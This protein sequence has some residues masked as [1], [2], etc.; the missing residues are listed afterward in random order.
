M[1]SPR[2][3]FWGVRGSFPAALPGCRQ[4][5]GNTAC[6]E[7]EWQGYHLIVDSGTG[8]RKLGERLIANPPGTPLHLLLSHPHWD[9]IQGFPFFAPAYSEEMT[10][11]VHSLR[12]TTSMRSL[13]SDQQRATYFSTP[14]EKMQ[15]DLSFLEWEEGEVFRPGPF[16]V[17][18]WRLNH[19]GICSGF[20]IR[21][22]DYILAYISDVAPCH[23]YLLADPLPGNPTQQEALRRLHENQFRLAEGAQSV[24]YDTFFTPQ[25]YSQ[26]SHWGHSTPEH[27]LEVCQSCN[28]QNLFLFHHNSEIDD[29]HQWER[30]QHLAIPPTLTVTPAQEGPCYKLVP[31]KLQP[32]E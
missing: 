4:L 32:C 7:L 11:R 20:R 5:G 21:M 27:A 10:L 23:E 29:S 16:E 14:L 17:V 13:L 26:R 18:T 25:Q 3:R 2:L 31:G 22:D 1:N 12:R 30:L 24:I 28:N 6:I 15:S 9:H 8:I 19:P